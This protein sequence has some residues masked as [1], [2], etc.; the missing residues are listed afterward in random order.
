MTMIM[1]RL[2]CAAALASLDVFEKDGVLEH[3]RDVGTRFV[4]GLRARL[5]P[6]PHVGDIRMKGLFGGVELV[7][8]RGTREPYPF[9]ERTGHRVCLAA[10]DRGVFLRP[11]GDVIVLVPPLSS[12]DDELDRLVTALA[13]SVREATGD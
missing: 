8:D 6:L 3:V 11:L 2:G 1:R 10:R 7:K 5:G 12:T 4:E 9:A 13:A